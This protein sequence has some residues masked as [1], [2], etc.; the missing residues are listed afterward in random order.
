MKMQNPQPRKI[1]L[2]LVDERDYDT[3]QAIIAWPIRWIG[4]FVVSVLFAIV[5]PAIILLGFALLF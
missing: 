4:I 2:S 3:V 5:F 1:V